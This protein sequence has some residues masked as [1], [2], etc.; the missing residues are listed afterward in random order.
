MTL[1]FN[2]WK[3]C[4]G[5]LGDG[6]S[7]ASLW[8]SKNV[9][10]SKKLHQTSA[11][12]WVDNDKSSFVKFTCYAQNLNECLNLGEWSKLNILLGLS[13]D[14]EIKNISFSKFQ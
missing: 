7:A 10:W 13:S 11:K 1:V 8:G 5:C 9:L 6:C 2:Y 14:L 4:F 12:G 3:R